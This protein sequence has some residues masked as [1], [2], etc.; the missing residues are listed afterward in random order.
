MSTVALF[1]LKNTTA[2][3]Y[4]NYGSLNTLIEKNRFDNFGKKIDSWN[5]F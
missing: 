3:Q 5:S 4:C 1:N 2:F